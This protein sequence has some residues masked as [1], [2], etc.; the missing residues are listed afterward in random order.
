MIGR[1][2]DDFSLQNNLQ[3]L[4]FDVEPVL[5][6]P[7]IVIDQP[8]NRLRR[9]PLEIYSC[10]LANINEEIQ[11]Q[12]GEHNEIKVVITVPGHFDIAQREAILEAAEEVGFKVLKL[13]NK[14]TAIAL[15]YFFANEKF[16]KGDY[17]LIYNLGSGSFNVA[18][19]KMLD[20]TINTVAVIGNNFLGGFDIDSL[21]LNFVCDS[22][23]ERYNFDVREDK[24]RLNQLRHACEGAKKLFQILMI[25]QLELIAFQMLIFVT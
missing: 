9:S 2:F 7:V 5:N 17:F 8:T 22:L 18:I 19:Y 10:I 15:S 3:H 11:E 12:L 23:K 25:L 20:F 1:K 21:I 24:M 14:P 6:N 4:S 16:D 13:L